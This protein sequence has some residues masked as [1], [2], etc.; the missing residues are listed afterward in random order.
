M[1]SLGNQKPVKYQQTD[2]IRILQEED[3]YDEVLSHIRKLLEEAQMSGGKH[4]LHF[5]L[6]NHIS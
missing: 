3:D 5:Y 2:F 6:R 4:T 1:D